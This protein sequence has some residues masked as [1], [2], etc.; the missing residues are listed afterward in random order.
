M[1][2]WDSKYGFAKVVFEDEECPLPSNKIRIQ[3]RNRRLRDRR[4]L[5]SGDG[6][7]A[8]IFSRQS[9]AVIYLIVGFVYALRYHFCPFCGRV[10]K[11]VTSYETGERVV[12]CCSCGK[13]LN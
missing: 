10:C 11:Y 2:L 3:T 1:R 8:E 12:T 5:M 7:F 6:S 4:L 9:Q 13:R